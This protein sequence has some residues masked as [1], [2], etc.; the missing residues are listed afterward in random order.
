M[1]ILSGQITVVTAGT[2][3]TG[4]TT[5]TDAKFELKAHPGNTG[6]AWVGNDGADDVTSVNGYPLN[7]AGES[8]VVDLSPLSPVGDNL[9]VFQFDATTSGDIICWAIIG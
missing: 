5:P 9:S 3:V 6:A 8:M 2:A 4:P 1:A 7:P